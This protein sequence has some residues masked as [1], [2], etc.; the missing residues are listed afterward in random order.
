[1]LKRTLVGAAVSAALITPLA[2]AEKGPAYDTWIGGFAQYYDVDRDKP[3]PNGYMDEGDGFGVELGFRFDPHWAARFEVADM[4]IDPDPNNPFGI[5]E[6]GTSLGADVMYFLDND[7]AYLFGGI[8]QQNLDQNYRGL[9]AGIG[10]HWGVNERVKVITEV[11]ALHDFGDGYNDYNVKVGFAYT[12]G[13]SPSVSTPKDSDNDGVIDSRDQCPNTPPGT[14]VD[15]NGCNNDLDG[16]GVVNAQDKCPNTPPNTPVDATG[17]RLV[18]DADNDGVPDN[19]DK[20]PDSR[21]N[22]KVD[23]TGCVIFEEKELSVSLN[24]LFA[25]DSANVDNPNAPQLNEFAEFLKRFVNT[26]VVIEGHT[27][28]VGPRDYNQGLSE[29]RAKAVREVLITQ[30]GIE[31]GRISA[32]GYGETRLLDTSNSAEAHRNNRRIE[33]KVSA[34]VKEPQQ[35]N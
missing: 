7:V 29:R 26:S 10:K 27:S 28:A 24:V 34:T 25:N 8:R 1:M 35:T 9:M 17:C 31:A 14:A 13:G 22:D 32:V 19:K 16:D 5:E 33:A 4:T 30:Y 15:T 3:E 18:G 2:L 11:G 20:C 6:D 23:A 12:F 21:P